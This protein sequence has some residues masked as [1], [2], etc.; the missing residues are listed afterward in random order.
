MEYEQDWPLVEVLIHRFKTIARSVA[1]NIFLTKNTNGAIILADPI[2]RV[3]Q[4]KYARLLKVSES[5]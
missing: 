3:Y 1:H 5:Q 4:I 2:Y